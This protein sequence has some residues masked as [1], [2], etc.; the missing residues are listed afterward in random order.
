MP[1]SHHTRSHLSIAHLF[2]IFP[3]FN[4][5]TNRGAQLWPSNCPVSKT[6]A[7]PFAGH[8]RLGHESTVSEEGQRIIKGEWYW[9]AWCTAWCQGLLSCSDKL[10]L[11]LL[12]WLLAE[13]HDLCIILI[14]AKD[15]NF[16]CLEVPVSKL[17]QRPCAPT[18]S[19][20]AHI[21]LCLLSCRT[22]A[23]HSMMQTSCRLCQRAGS[24]PSTGTLMACCGEWM[25]PVRLPG[26][27]PPK[28]RQQHNRPHAIHTVSLIIMLLSTRVAAVSASKTAST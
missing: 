4:Q 22:P 1:T 28:A 23:L 21:L 20:T 19:T 25:C 7:M 14:R 10:W 12:F 9:P 5:T 26:L 11:L 6:T 16:L 2:S 27:E 15:N 17:P 13:C 24:T 18:L 8:V 3:A